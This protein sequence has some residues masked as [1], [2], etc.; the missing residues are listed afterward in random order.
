MRG[1][2][3]EAHEEGQTLLHTE[4]RGSRIVDALGRRVW[5]GGLTHPGDSSRKHFDLL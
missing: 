2:N 1:S 5:L 3:G 4:D